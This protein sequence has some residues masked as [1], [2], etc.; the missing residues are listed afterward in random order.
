M[1][2]HLAGGVLATLAALPVAEARAEC[3]LN[4]VPAQYHA[5]VEAE[6]KYR[7]ALGRFTDARQISLRQEPL[8]STKTTVYE[9]TFTGNLASM[10]GF[11]V[12]LTT[13]VTITVDEYLMI[14]EP[15]GDF[16]P[17]TEMIVVLRHEGGKYIFEPGMCWFGY[18]VEPSK[19]DIRDL[20]SCIRGNNCPE[21]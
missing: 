19:K 5:Y 11:V 17:D 8:G 13:P 1:R 21:F 20:M 6:E 15:Q 12:P 2:R 18:I 3:V 14:P 7:F 4:S 10:R 16:H 9:A